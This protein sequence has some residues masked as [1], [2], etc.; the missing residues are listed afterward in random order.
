MVCSGQWNISQCDVREGTGALGRAL[1]CCWGRPPSPAM[2]TVRKSGLLEGET[3]GGKD[4]SSCWFLWTSHPQPEGTSIPRK[5]WPM[6]GDLLSCPN[7]IW[8]WRRGGVAGIEWVKAQG[9]ANFSQRPWRT[10]NEVL[11]CPKRRQC[12]PS[13]NPPPLPAWWAAAPLVRPAGRP[14]RS[15]PQSLTHS[16]ESK[17]IVVVSRHYIWE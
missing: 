9:A 10:Q 14:C 2:P 6:S 12:L 3:T 16:T 7:C 13:T 1:S 17:K 4:K 15:Q 8:C 11:S 5:Q